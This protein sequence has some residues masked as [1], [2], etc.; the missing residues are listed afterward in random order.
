MSTQPPRGRQGRNGGSRGGRALMLL[1]IV[2]ALLAGV[3]V[4]YIVRNA[5]QTAGANQPGC[6]CHPTYKLW[7]N[8]RCLIDT[9][10]LYGEELPGG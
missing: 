10:I 4:I 3:L 1:G 9:V 5:T 8:F 2:L 6:G 7:P